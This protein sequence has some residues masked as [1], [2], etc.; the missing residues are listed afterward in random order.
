VG[1]L[2]R[3]GWVYLERHFDLKGIMKASLLPLG[4]GAVV[5]SVGDV[6]LLRDNGEVI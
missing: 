5:A 2:R 4:K 1:S 3:I 6:F